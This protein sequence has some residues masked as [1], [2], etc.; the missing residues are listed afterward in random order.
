MR[1]TSRGGLTIEFEAVGRE[2]Q[3]V[4]LHGFFGDRTT[5]YSAG[6]VDALA[7]GFRL[8][9]IDARGHGDS[10]A[11]PRRRQLRDQPSGR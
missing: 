5:S 3:L 8:V 2:D 6:H 7:G 11:L 9:M 1:I 10:E 4:L